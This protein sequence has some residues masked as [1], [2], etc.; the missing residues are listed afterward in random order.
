MPKIAKDS[1]TQSNL[2][3]FAIGLASGFALWILFC[4]F[5]QHY[6][7]VITGWCKVRKT[8]V[9]PDSKHIAYL[10]NYSQGSALGE[11]GSWV[12]VEPT[13]SRIDPRISESRVFEIDHFN[14]ASASGI[15][16]TA[17][18]KLL[19]TYFIPSG[20]LISVWQR[21]SEGAKSVP[22]ITSS[23]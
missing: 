1:D 12:V 15:D 9:S 20:R 8:I 18:N 5:W 21:C 19:I 3:F 13:T 6:A 23:R 14:G 17:D 11:H 4:S 16:W 7:P 10:I 22:I 2:A